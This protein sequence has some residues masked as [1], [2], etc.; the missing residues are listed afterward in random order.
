MSKC[1]ICCL[2]LFVSV[3]HVVFDEIHCLL[4]VLQLFTFIPLIYGAKARFFRDLRHFNV[5]RERRTAFT[6]LVRRTIVGIE[7]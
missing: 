5:P 7:Y 4:Q 2:I 1:P 3:I 6:G